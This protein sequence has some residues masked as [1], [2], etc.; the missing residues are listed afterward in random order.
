MSHDVTDPLE[1]ITKAVF[2][3]TASPQATFKVKVVTGEAFNLWVARGQE[4]DAETSE[5]SMVKNDTGWEVQTEW[6]YE[7]IEGEENATYIHITGGKWGSNV[8]SVAWCNVMFE[9]CNVISK[10]PF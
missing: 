9:L 4:A 1:K 8:V 2:Y 3:T 6:L 10:S 7:V 5:L